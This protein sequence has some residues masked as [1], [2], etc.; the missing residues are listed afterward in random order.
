MGSIT[1]RVVIKTDASLF[2]WGAVCKGQTVRGPCGEHK[3]YRISILE[4]KK[5]SGSETLCQVGG[6]HN[7]IRSDK[8]AMI[9]YINCQNGVPSYVMHQNCL[10]H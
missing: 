4:L 7:V 9:T 8:T 3:N 10:C 2:G 6:R 5:G 1:L